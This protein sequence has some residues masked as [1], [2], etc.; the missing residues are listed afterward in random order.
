MTRIPSDDN[1]SLERM[2]NIMAHQCR[3]K[4]AQEYD[5]LE[6]QALHDFIGYIRQEPDGCFS[7]EIWVWGVCRERFYADTIEA[8][9]NAALMAAR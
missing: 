4:A 7:N 6:V 8:V 1:F 9:K 3:V 5:V 2:A